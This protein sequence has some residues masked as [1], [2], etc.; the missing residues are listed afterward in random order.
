MGTSTIMKRKTEV[1]KTK[2]GNTCTYQNNYGIKMEPT[3]SIESK[4]VKNFIAEAKDFSNFKTSGYCNQIDL[5][6]HTKENVLFTSQMK[7]TTLE[8]TKLD[9]KFVK[10]IKESN[11]DCLRFEKDAASGSTGESMK[12]LLSEKSNINKVEVN[13]CPGHIWKVL[14]CGIYLHTI[15]FRAYV[16]QSHMTLPKFY[17]LENLNQL[18]ITKCLFNNCKTKSVERKFFKN[19]NKSNIRDLTYFYH[20]HGKEGTRISF[21]G[22]ADENL[23]KENKNFQQL[24]NLDVAKNCNVNFSLR[25]NF[26]KRFCRFFFTRVLVKLSD[27]AKYTLPWKIFK[28]QEVVVKLKFELSKKLVPRKN[29]NARRTKRSTR[30]PANIDFNFKFTMD[31][32]IEK[33]EPSVTNNNSYF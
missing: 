32:F 16:F 15:E 31:D 17:K 18:T 12:K 11:F 13:V 19:L 6:L 1:F 9:S 4:N 29:R 28:E 10:D 24:F 26:T 20:E 2:F 22:R 8:I 33:P 5:Y 27:I 23:F 25:G 14:N 7:N 21:E 3:A 30:M